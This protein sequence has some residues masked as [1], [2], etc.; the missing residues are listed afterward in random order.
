MVETASCRDDSFRP[1]SSH[2][3]QARLN[4]ILDA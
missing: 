1:I 3:F 4:V 2:K